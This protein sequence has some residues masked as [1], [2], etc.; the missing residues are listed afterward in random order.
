MDAA[1]QADYQKR[2][3]DY[4]DT[5]DEGVVILDAVRDLT[6]PTYGIVMETQV[7]GRLVGGGRIRGLTRE[8]RRYV[9]KWTSNPKEER[10]EPIQRFVGRM[11]EMD[12][13]KSSFILR[14]IEGIEGERKFKFSD[15]LEDEVNRLWGDRAK[16]EVVAKVR[17]HRSMALVAIKAISGTQAN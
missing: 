7:G 17:K 10:P 11:R 8:A 5:E 3:A 6:P 13:D 14:E 12:L 16:V 4:F 15:D 1:S 9:N 2:L